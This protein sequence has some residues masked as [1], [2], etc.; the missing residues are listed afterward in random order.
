M[1]D[2]LGQSTYWDDRLTG[3]ADLSEWSIYWDSRPNGRRNGFFIECGAFDGEE[4]SNSLMLEK[5][6][7]WTGLLIEPDPDNFAQM[8]S[9]NRKAFLVNGGLHGGQHP[10]ALVLHKLA[11]ASVLDGYVDEKRKS[12]DSYIANNTIKATKVWCFPLLSLLLAVGQTRVDYFSLDV[13][14]AEYDILSTLPL[15]KI[16]LNL[17]Q[18]EYVKFEEGEKEQKA[19]LLR[20]LMRERYKQFLEVAKTPMD[21]FYLNSNF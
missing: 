4:K 7:N 11:Y 21:V 3:T 8:V 6:L 14:G 12:F 20:K 19:V 16:Q 1:V 10:K 5:S 9:R 18:M 17:L 15:D 2:L 13:E